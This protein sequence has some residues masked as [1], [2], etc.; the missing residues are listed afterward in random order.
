M[1]Q[2]RHFVLTVGIIS[3]VLGCAH[4]PMT[5]QSAMSAANHFAKHLGYRLAD[6]EPPKVEGS[7]KENWVFYYEP[8][9]PLTEQ[10]FNGPFVTNR[11][12]IVVNPQTGKAQQIIYAEP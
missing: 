1:S 10:T 7:A 5:K 2:F 11:L 3:L 12:G 8:K 6:Y 4:T 9:V